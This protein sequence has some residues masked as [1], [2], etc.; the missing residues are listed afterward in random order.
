[1]RR[2]VIAAAMATGLFEPTGYAA[3]SIVI[4]AAVIAGLVGRVLPAG[5]V[6]DTAAVAGPLPG[7]HGASRHR[8]R[9]LGERSGTSVRGGREGLVLPRSVHAGRLHGESRRAQPSGW[10][11]STIGLATVSVIAVL[12]YLQ[13]GL[14]GSEQSDI[15]NAAGRLSYPI[16]YWNGAGGPAGGGSDP[17]L[18]RVGR[19]AP[20][21]AVR[22]VGHRRDSRCRCSVSGSPAPGVAAVAAGRRAGGPGRRFAR[23]PE[24]GRRDR[25]GAGRDGAC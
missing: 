1:M 23:S 5:P 16:G 12:A 7:R 10:P 2:R 8:V 3:A 9:R 18:L 15:P 20:T 14:L 21:R 13:P 6:G 22:A 11:A 25:P 17:A 19:S 4:W 24:A